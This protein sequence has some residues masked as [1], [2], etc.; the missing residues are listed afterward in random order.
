MTTFLI[1]LVVIV[2]VLLAMGVG[3]L[4]GRG[5]P[6]RGCAHIMGLD[7]ACVSCRQRRQG[8]GDSA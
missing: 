4:C 3:V 7:D 1:T 5:P 8:D 6:A 2:L